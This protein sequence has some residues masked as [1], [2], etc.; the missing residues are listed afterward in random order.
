MDPPRAALTDAERALP[1]E[2]RLF[3][4]AEATDEDVG[5]AP[6]AHDAS[7]S[8]VGDTNG[9][10]LAAPLP[11]LLLLLRVPPV[12]GVL[13]ALLVRSLLGDRIWKSLVLLP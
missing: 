7:C 4:N 9:D 8:V 10:R 12:E 6:E 5:D 1:G 13:V 11:P 2:S 3:S